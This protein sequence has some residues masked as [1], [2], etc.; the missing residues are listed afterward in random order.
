MSIIQ[1]KKL[2]FSRFSGYFRRFLG[3]FMRIH[4]VKEEEKTPALIA[5]LY[6]ISEDVLV[7]P[8]E[9]G[10]V[11]AQ[12]R[13]LLILTPTRTYLSGRTDTVAG[14]AE[15]F[16]VSKTDILRRNPPI[17]RGEAL[18]GKELAVKYDVPPL[19]TCAVLGFLFRGVKK[20]RLSFVLPYLTHLAVGAYR[21]RGTVLERMFNPERAVKMS[22]EAGICPFLRV[23]DCTYGAFLD[24]GEKEKRLA[25]ALV[26]VAR[27]GNFS[28]IVLSSHPTGDG[29]KALV[30]FL[31]KLKKLSMDAGLSLLFEGDEKTPVQ[32]SE[33][34]D[35]GVFIYDKTYLPNIPSFDDGERKALASF[36]EASECGGVFVDIPGEGFYTDRYV[37]INEILNSRRVRKI[38]T[39]QASLV[40]SA[41][42][43]TDVIKF[44]SLG[45]VEQRLRLVRELGFLG[46]SVNVGNVP[47]EHLMA[48]HSLFSPTGIFRPF[49][50]G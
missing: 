38:E 19:G 32:I 20:E 1:R 47:T 22:L 5:E 42:V 50:I 30:S 13:E 4:T 10:G 34:T 3:D 26:S 41:S 25:E 21:I 39:D 12:G 8:N 35:G 44:P 29:Q 14:I 28:G 6:G 16:R 33:V 40:S 7:S 24:G 27:T 36:S 18:W 46:V 49:S 37:P 43:G 9:Y 15:R 11:L 31:L 48:I 17:G 45:N 23:F 2:R